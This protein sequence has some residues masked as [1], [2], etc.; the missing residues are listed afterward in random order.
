MVDAP[1]PFRVRPV[2]NIEDLAPDLIDDLREASQ[3]SSNYGYGA[4][5]DELWLMPERHDLM[6]EFLAGQASAGLFAKRFREWFW[7]PGSPIQSV[8]E[9]KM[10]S[11]ADAFA[12]V[13]A[14]HS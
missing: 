6:Q 10:A 1:A 3:T 2:F 4:A 7:R 13:R 5:F 14:G 11:I 12:Q 8:E 9:N